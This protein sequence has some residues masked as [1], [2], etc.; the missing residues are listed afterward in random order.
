VENSQVQDALVR[1]QA[2]YLASPALKVTAYQAPHQWDLP[3]DV[4]DTALA[5]LVRWGFLLQTR[6]GALVRESWDAS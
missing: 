4:C 5:L 6:E 2:G 3:Q 1:I